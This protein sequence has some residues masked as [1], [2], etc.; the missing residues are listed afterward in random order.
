MRERDYRSC[1]VLL[2]AL[3]LVAT[4]CTEEI[5]SDPASSALQ[6][7]PISFASSTATSSV[8]NRYTT[9]LYSEQDVDVYNR[10]GAGV[11]FEQGVTVRAIYVEVGDAVKAGQTLAVLEDDDV[12]LDLEAARARA[13]DA[14]AQFERIEDLRQREFVSPS[15]YDAA[16]AEKREAVAELRRAELNISRTR[17]RAP[18]AGVVS[19]RYVRVGELVE[20]GIALFRVTAMNPLRARIL[21]PESQA[22]AFTSG[23]PVQ[24]SGAN[25]QNA[26]GRVLVVGPT[27]DAASGT[28]EVIVELAEPDGFRPGGAV[29]AE[30]LAPAE[31]A[32]R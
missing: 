2:M 28:R 10:L 14:T 21:V 24:L 32:E 25:G 30:P 16:L 23:A 18:F 3:G 17:V 15:E 26:T 8:D 31:S 12:Q 13:D 4:G 5:E 1:V 6:A 7:A 27:V 20:E 22:S 19:R 9:Y 29:I 11:F